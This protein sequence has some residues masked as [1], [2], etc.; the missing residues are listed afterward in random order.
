MK[1][2]PQE[3]PGARPVG[4][5]RGARPLA[6]AFLSLRGSVA[7]FNPKDEAEM[8][9]AGFGAWNFR[10]PGSFGCLCWGQPAAEEEGG[11]R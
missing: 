8:V 6:F 11:F 10:R 3:E 1:Q 7:C 9:M 5:P 4:S 2:Q